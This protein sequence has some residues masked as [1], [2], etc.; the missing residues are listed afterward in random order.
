MPVFWSMLDSAS[1]ILA[2]CTGVTACALRS[3]C[4]RLHIHACGSNHAG[5][6]VVLHHELTVP[7]GRLHP[8]GKLNVHAPVR[9][10]VHCRTHDLQQSLL[11]ML[12][13]ATQSLAASQGAAVVAGKAGERPF[14]AVSVSERCSASTLVTVP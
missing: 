1:G 12:G 10:I 2:A 5:L 14:D 3:T 13:R 4:E 9:K 6:A 11:A 7:V 8:S